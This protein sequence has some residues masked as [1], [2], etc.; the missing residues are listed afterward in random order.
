LILDRRTVYTVAEEYSW[1]IV[2]KVRNT[3]GRD[4]RYVQISFA[5]YDAAGNKENSGIVNMNDLPAGETWSFKKHVY[6]ETSSGGKW[7]IESLWGT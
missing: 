4:F 1:S 3:C 5:F 2:G 7:S 6:E